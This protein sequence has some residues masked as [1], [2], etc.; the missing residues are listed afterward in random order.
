MA[1]GLV[2]RSFEGLGLV[3][4]TPVVLY[5]QEPKEKVWGLLLALETAGV[6]VQKAIK[7]LDSGVVSDVAP[8]GDGCLGDLLLNARKIAFQFFA[9]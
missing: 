6:L 8:L 7:C 4:G 1:E 5:L 9:L 2:A 3:S